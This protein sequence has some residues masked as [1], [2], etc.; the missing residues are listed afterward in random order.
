[1]GKSMPQDL[2]PLFYS[3]LPLSV[4]SL[5]V[6]R[7]VLVQYILP[8]RVGKVSFR[9]IIWL[10]SSTHG[11]GCGISC[12]CSESSVMVSW[13]RTYAWTHTSTLA[14]CSRPHEGTGRQ[15]LLWTCF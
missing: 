7:G 15:R 13:T 3:L 9:G 14:A 2:S 1:L 8:S 6:T 12:S 4:A 10:S 11:F 5:V